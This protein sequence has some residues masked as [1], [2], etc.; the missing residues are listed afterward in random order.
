[1]GMTSREFVVHV[2]IKCA[3]RSTTCG[4]AVHIR[5][6]R[7]P[8][9]LTGAY[10]NVSRFRVELLAML[11]ALKEVRKLSFGRYSLVTLYTCCDY[12]ASVFSS[13]LQ[14]KWE[15][16]KYANVK[17]ADLWRKIFGMYQAMNLRVLHTNEASDLREYELC[18][19]D[20]AF[21]LQHE[22]ALLEERAPMAEKTFRAFRAYEKRLASNEQKPDELVDLLLTR[23]SRN[24][25]QSIFGFIPVIA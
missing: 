23:L 4:W 17:H 20:A 18:K 14:A 19:A 15:R 22:P 8:V 5:G 11:A 24:V 2:H 6:G 13:D 3:E 16:R 9:V 10:H 25:R 1:M 7:E 12:V 21:A